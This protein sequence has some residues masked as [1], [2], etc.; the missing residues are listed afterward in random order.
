M[1][2]VSHIELY[3]SDYKTSIRFYDIVLA[4]IG[5]KRLNCCKNFTAYSDGFLKIVLGPT[6]DEYIKAGYHR[7]RTG[8]NHLAFYANSRNEVDSFVENVLKKHE[9]AIL[10]EQGAFGD[11]D[12]YSVFF[13]DPDRIKLELVYAPR[14]CD[15]GVWPNT[16]DDDFDPYAD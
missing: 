12:Y 6:D 7:K 5:F 10:Y 9:I 2:R 13:E 15:E 4:E 14:Y 8:L 11:D 1:T 3:V 16:V